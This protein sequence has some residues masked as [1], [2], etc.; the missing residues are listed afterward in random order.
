[1]HK[2]FIPIALL[3]A[4]LWVVPTTAAQDATAEATENPH[5]PLPQEVI[6]MFDYDQDSPLNIEEVSSEMR[7]DVEIKDITYTSP[8]DDSE[9]S[10]YLIV[11]AGEGPFPGILYVHWLE[12]GDPTSNRTQ[13]VDE[14]VGLA[15]TDGVMSLL[16]STM[17]SEPN[18]YERRSL[19]TDYEDALQQVI[20]LRRALDVLFAQPQIASERIAYVGHD[21]GAMYGSLMAGVDH[22]PIAYVMI[23]GASNFNHWMLFGVSSTTPGLDEY[24]AH[25]DELA[26]TRFIG[27]ADAPVLFQFGTID[28]YTPREDIDLFYAAAAEP[29]QLELYQ[30]GHPMNLRQIQEDRLAFLREQLGLE[31]GPLSKKQF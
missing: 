25:M 15:D 9:I 5:E 31:A 16:I 26:P 10:A 28:F 7:G 22:R 14:A 20:E 1:M 8:V 18:W 29:K 19:A 12:N 21:F 13:F 6:A 17:W 27:Q 30:S 4:L 11:P 2:N 3:L 23:A 24:K